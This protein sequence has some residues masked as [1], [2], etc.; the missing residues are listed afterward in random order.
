[1]KTDKDCR[2][3]DEVDKTMQAFD[4]DAPIASNPFLAS[5]IRFLHSSR[6]RDKGRVLLIRLS[7]N[8]VLMIVVLLMNLIT[9]AYWIDRHTEQKLQ[10]RLVSEL[11]NDFQIDQSQNSY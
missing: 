9:A 6:S 2:V 10:E 1:M 11:K 8:Q 7:L 5:R 4:D 3:A